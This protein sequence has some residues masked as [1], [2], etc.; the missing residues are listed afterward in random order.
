MSDDPLKI[1]IFRGFIGIIIATIIVVIFKPFLSIS[2]GQMVCGNCGEL[3]SL[4][5]LVIMIFGSIGIVMYKF[6]KVFYG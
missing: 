6:M 5:L 2:V 3:T 4:L 1:I